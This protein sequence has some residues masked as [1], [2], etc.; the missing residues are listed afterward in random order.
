MTSP[1]PRPP[2]PRLWRWLA[3]GVLCLA[4]VAAVV[5]RAHTIPV[6]LLGLVPADALGYLQLSAPGLGQPGP[7]LSGLAVDSWVHTLSG[8]S[9]WAD[10]MADP[11]WRQL[12]VVWLAP[13]EPPLLLAQAR[14]GLAPR[15][16]GE[17]RRVGARVY[18][19]G[20][21]RT[22]GEGEPSLRGRLGERAAGRHTVV[23]YLATTT[24]LVTSLDTQVVQPWLE[25]LPTLGSDGWL[26]TADWRPGFW[27]FALTPLGAAAGATAAAAGSS[28][29]S[30]GAP[31]LSPHPDLSVLVHGV[32]ASALT[33]WLARQSRSAYDLADLLASRWDSL[34]DGGSVDLALGAAGPA[35][36][37]T[38]PPFAIAWR[39][40]SGPTTVR[41]E[42]E[43]LAAALQRQP[44]P[45]LLPDGTAVVE[46]IAD[47]LGMPWP[48]AQDRGMLM[49]TAASNT[50]AIAVD[51]LSVRL[52]SDAEVL[53]KAGATWPASSAGRVLACANADEPWLLLRTP[54]PSDWGLGSW[55]PAPEGWL[56]LAADAGG[57]LAGCWQ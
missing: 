31:L 49:V 37:T 54:A 10:A 12:A 14:A 26:A 28:A 21:G 35:H 19:R 41:R 4:A 13:G 45:L 44:R 39:L 7:S 3:L 18:A 27:R 5:V 9:G 17:W 33:P 30:A 42:L 32:S 48:A 25:S 20:E 38:A 56:L 50:V 2:R 46:E 36:A 52:A 55:P 57:G 47:G 6:D 23:G 8:E 34:T 51:G 16:E 43:R 11:W 40:S 24:P 15:R 1:T 53:A 29:V 22:I